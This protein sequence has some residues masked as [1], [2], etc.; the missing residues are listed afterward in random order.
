MWS[1]LRHRIHANINQIKVADY[2]FPH[3]YDSACNRP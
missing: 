1:E 2:F 3:R